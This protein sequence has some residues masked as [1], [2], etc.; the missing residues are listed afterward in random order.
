M[1]K[2]IIT[3][4]AF[5]LFTGPGWVDS[6]LSLRDRFF[7]EGK[8]SVVISIDGW[9]QSLFPLLGLA[10]L[11]FGIWW[12]RDKKPR[13]TSAPV[14]S[15][16]FSNASPS[17]IETHE[18][19]P[20]IF[21]LPSTDNSIRLGPSTFLE[22]S[23]SDLVG[24]VRET[25]TI[26]ANRLKVPYIGNQIRVTANVNDVREPHREEQ[27]VALRE[28]PSGAIILAYFNKEWAEEIQELRKGQEIT[29]VGL[30][31]DINRFGIDL[32]S[33]LVARRLDA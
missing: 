8:E 22:V 20:D 10:I 5:A 29:I 6:L 24:I 26:E 9:Y 2:Y 32:T 7:G 14:P 4:L 12:T 33:C 21:P 23:V 15:S 27:L 13:E 11:L 28:E 18:K 1:R 30:I 25:T 17:L 31:K 16:T 19:A 3:G